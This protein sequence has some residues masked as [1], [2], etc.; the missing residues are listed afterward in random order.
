MSLRLL[1]PLNLQDADS[2]SFLKN[3]S[4]GSELSSGSG[5][6]VAKKFVIDFFFYREFSICEAE[7][8]RSRWDV[9]MR[10]IESFRQ[11]YIRRRNRDTQ[12]R[13][14]ARDA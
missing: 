7:A 14:V 5:R 2:S 10:K 1:N 4:M 13:L 11:Q 3:E 8:K 12:G 9:F 6:Y